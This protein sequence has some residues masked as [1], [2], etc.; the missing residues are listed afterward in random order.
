M[1]DIIEKHAC[2]GDNAMCGRMVPEKRQGLEAGGNR[3]SSEMSRV[4]W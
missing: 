3:W 4:D 2:I 1:T